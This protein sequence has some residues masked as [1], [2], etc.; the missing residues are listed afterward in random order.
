MGIK[1]GHKD[2]SKVRLILFIALIVLV[3]ASVVT[4]VFFGLIHFATRLSFLLTGFSIVG[5]I[6]LNWQVII[7][8]FK[9]SGTVTGVHKLI[10]FIIIL[11]ILVSL[12]LLADSLFWK[13][14]LTSSRLYRFSEQTHQIIKKVTNDMNIMLFKGKSPPSLL[15]EYQENLLRAYSRNNPHIHLEII[16]PW[17][18][19]VKA[20]KYGVEK[21]GTVVIEYQGNLATVMFEEIFSRNEE[22]Q[23][24]FQGE[25]AYTSALLKLVESKV[26][27]AYI[28]RG[29]GEPSFNSDYS[30]GYSIITTKMKSDGINIMD[31]NFHY[32]ADVPKNAGVLIIN[33]PVKM[34]TSEDLAKIKRYIDEGGNL[35]L[36]LD[37]ETD[38][39]I[40]DVLQQMGLFLTKPN[41]II[42]QQN[43]SPEQGPIVF[44]PNIVYN[45]EITA[46]LLEFQLGI[47]LSTA[48]A[49][50]QLSEEHR[51][52]GYHFQYWPLLKTSA[53][54]WGEISKA[55]ISGDKKLRYDAGVDLNGPLITAYAVKRIKND[56]YTNTSGDIRTN[57]IESRIVVFGD[58]HFINNQ[59]IYRGTG[60]S[61]LFLNA[62]N[63]LLKREG[64]VTVRPKPSNITEQ[65]NLNSFAQRFIPIL[66]ISIVL[67]YLGIGITVIV[68]RKRRVK[69]K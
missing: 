56:I 31:L 42:E 52:K 69:Q 17:L 11:G 48:V 50:D 67:I 12:Y 28:L 63:Y 37:Y 44:M 38:Y 62:I 47:I 68:R 51:P 1:N 19:R 45:K 46:P 61:D 43:Y 40:N 10:Q 26:K 5:I 54:A 35:L 29:H 39:I 34:F 25:V 3:F 14:D 8:F 23:I 64:D 24:M 13:I 15:I 49:I 53:N 7:R 57:T 21:N 9:R 33:N 27:N 16:D 36:L 58:S 55:E 30:T 59:T 60:N 65:Y 2:L 20:S 4:Y 66:A 6:V 32:S 22:G 18:N 41:L